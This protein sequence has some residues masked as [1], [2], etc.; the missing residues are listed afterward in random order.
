[1][2]VLSSTINLKQTAEVFRWGLELSLID[3]LEVWQWC[4]RVATQH[5]APPQVLVDAARMQAPGEKALEQI[6]MQVPGQ[7]Y[8]AAV[9]RRVF[10]LQ[11]GY[12]NESRDRL[13]VVL[14]QF[15]AELFEAENIGGEARVE[16]DYF[17][18]Q[19][20]DIEHGVY[21]DGAG[22]AATDELTGN[23]LAFLQHAAQGNLAAYRHTAAKWPRNETG[24]RHFYR[25]E[26][27]LWLG[28][29]VVMILLFQLV[30]SNLFVAAC[31]VV[32]L[33]LRLLWRAKQALCDL[34]P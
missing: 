15:E 11:C 10:A 32:F 25:N 9:A 21:M 17:L 19:G 30:E 14:K 16:L 7:C 2:S 12:L 13:A 26:T 1:M 3:P 24:Y 34:L 18:A 29:M 6:L 5:P 23:V 4:E 33:V 27:L 31:F 8:T 28:A 22:A 20:D